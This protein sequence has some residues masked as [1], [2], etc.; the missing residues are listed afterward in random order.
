MKL[1]EKFLFDFGKSFLKK[2]TAS[3]KYH[4]KLD[5]TTLIEVIKKH[6][7][8]GHFYDHD[9]VN[10]FPDSL[11]QILEAE[12]TSLKSNASMYVE[13]L[14]RIAQSFDMGQLDYVLLNGPAVYQLIYEAPEL[15]PS[16][17][18]DILVP[19]QHRNA[20]EQMLV[21]SGFVVIES[22]VD[23]KESLFDHPNPNCKFF[24]DNING[25][26]VCMLW[27]PF[28]HS[29]IFSPDKELFSTKLEVSVDDFIVYI[30][31]LSDLMIYL[32]MK[33]LVRDFA[34]LNLLFDVSMFIN[35]FQSSMNWQVVKARAEKFGLT[36]QLYVGVYL[37]YYYLGSFMFKLEHNQK[38]VE[39]FVDEYIK[40]QMQDEYQMTPAIKDNLRKHLSSLKEYQKTYK[41]GGKSSIVSPFNKILG[42]FQK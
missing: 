11:K 22:P 33:G 24:R 2:E 14:K 41:I 29:L 27:S 9:I 19:E 40:A 16:S 12:V 15:H 34:F 18:I 39:L 36:S 1:E 6:K 4:D 8:L 13:T 37:G 5:D 31:S 20:S 42:W 25:I 10:Q 23:G 21:S 38:V 32:S 17:Q 28:P 30:P 3:L 26:E 35:R 7:M